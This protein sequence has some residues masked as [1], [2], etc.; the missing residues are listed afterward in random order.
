MTNF[1]IQKFPKTRLASFDILSVGKLKHHIV[2]LLECDVTNARQ[3][4]TEKKKQNIRITF[5]SWLLKAI[6]NTI[7]NHPEAAA[8]LYKKRKI[9]IFDEINISML[10]EKEINGSKVPIPVVIEKTNEKSIPEI[11]ME[12]ERAKAEKLSDKDMV[13]NEKSDFI[14]R[15][16]YHFPGFLRRM[17]WKI[18]LKNPKTVFKKMGNVVVTS[19]G[20]VGRINGWFIQTS[21]HPISFGIGSVIKKPVVLNDEIKI[22][23]VLNMTILIDHDV[24][25]GAP[26]TRFVN[27]LSKNIEN[28]S[29]LY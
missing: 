16:Y 18:M 19:V 4:I 12:I 7:N 5:N 15:C 9:I 22:R 21:I 2:I 6:S 14:E 8:Y 26:M 13:L 17:I 25:D 28:G 20:I 27:E 11:A 24:I 29:G 23:E 1:K 3:K 10:V